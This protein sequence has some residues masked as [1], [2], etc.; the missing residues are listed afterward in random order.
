MR[1]FFA[2]VTCA[3]L[4]V[5][6]IAS[7]SEQSQGSFARNVVL[8]YFPVLTIAFNAVISRALMSRLGAQVT[9][10][11]TFLAC[12]LMLQWVLLT[13]PE[14]VTTIGGHLLTAFSA[15]LYALFCL[16]HEPQDEI[17]PNIDR[18]LRLKRELPHSDN[19][20]PLT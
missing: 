17:H 15:T 13:D 11:I 16:R 12:L 8:L 10:V 18:L 20:G 3:A 4:I 5:Q 9:V 2:L 19:A 1:T 7:T 6:T 14:I